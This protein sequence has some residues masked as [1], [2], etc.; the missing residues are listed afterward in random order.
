[1]RDQLFA[2][3]MKF[4]EVQ[5]AWDYNEMASIRTP[6]CCGT[7]MAPS[8]KIYRPSDKLEGA[9]DEVKKVFKSFTFRLIEE[10]DMV[11]DEV[12]RKVVMRVGGQAETTVGPYSNEWVFILTMTEDGKLVSD[13]KNML[14]T[15]ILAELESRIQQ[16]SKPYMP[17]LDH[18]T[19]EEVKGRALHE[20][21]N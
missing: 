13:V 21:C 16:S 14:D 7:L 1:M 12:A 5:S 18:L 15:V 10:D 6:T 3:A 11:I 8:R 2:T 17:W 19:K 4:L 9:M 20:A